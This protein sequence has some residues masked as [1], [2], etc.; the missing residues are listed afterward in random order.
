MDD[1][2]NGDIKGNKYTFGFVK[3]DET[4]KKAIYELKAVKA[5]KAD[6]SEVS[7]KFNKVKYEVTSNW[8]E[9]NGKYQIKTTT[10]DT[11]DIQM[12]AIANQ[13]DKA[14]STGQLK[15]PTNPEDTGVDFTEI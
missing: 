9:V 4:N 15:N 14:V 3:Y 2:T 6:G 12:R 5:V 13:P 8:Q 11:N 7:T 1:A 10:G